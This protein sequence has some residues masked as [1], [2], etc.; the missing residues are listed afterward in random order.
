MPDLGG[1]DFGSRR[2]KTSFW[3]KRVIETDEV[4][5]LNALESK[6][7]GELDIQF[8]GLTLLEEER[9]KTGSPEEPSTTVMNVVW[10]QFLNQ[11]AAVAGG[12][13]HCKPQHE[14]DYQERYDSWMKNFKGG[15]AGPGYCKPA[16]QHRG[17]GHT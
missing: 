2:T 15:R 5:D 6:L 7:Q 17:S 10:Q 12:G 16:G 9:E 11:I 1:I 14:T 3:R 13:L 4:F 8:T